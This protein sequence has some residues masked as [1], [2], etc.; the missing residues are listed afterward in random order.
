MDI[1]RIRLINLL[2]L[3]YA[4]LIL[5]DSA[6]AYVMISFTESRA[7]MYRAHGSPGPLL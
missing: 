3:S 4:H 1:L 5:H 7:G 2:S 6:R